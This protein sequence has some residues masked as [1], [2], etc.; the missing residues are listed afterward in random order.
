MPDQDR[1]LASDRNGCD[2]MTAPGPDPHEEGVQRSR[3]L[4]CGPGGFDQH[5][6]RV[7]AADLA[8]AAMMRDARARLADAWI[9]PYIAHQL[10][11]CR[12]PGA[13]QDFRVRA[14]G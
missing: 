10:L 3:R 4:G 14:A 6:A 5:G 11:G 2:L 12:E 1:E 9:Q 13:C 8:N 7:A